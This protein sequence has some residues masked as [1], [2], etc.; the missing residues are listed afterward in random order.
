MR[1]T[2]L[3]SM[4]ALALALPLHAQERPER[5]QR[6]ERRVE[7]RVFTLRRA[8]EMGRR[9][10][11]VLGITTSTGQGLADTAGVLVQDVAENG[12]AARAGIQKGARLTEIDGIS[13][14][15]TPGDAEDPL[16]AS[17][18][19]RRLTRELGRKKPGDEVEL[20]VVTGAQSRNVRVRLAEP[21]SV[22]PR[23]APAPP[24]PVREAMRERMAN[25]ASLG[26][27]AGSSGSRRDTLGVFV[28]RADDDGPAARAGIVEGARIAAINGVDLRVDRA[29]ADDPMIAGAKVRQLM[30]E[31]RDVKPGDE[32]ELRVWQNGQYRTA[33][34][35]T[36]AADSLQ[37]TR[38]AVIVGDGPGV[39]G[40]GMRIPQGADFGA[41]QFHLA[42]EFHE[43]LEVIIDGALQGA[44]GAMEGAR[45]EIERV[46]RVQ[47]HH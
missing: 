22:F 13:L 15:M 30:R 16:L 37:R 20:R 33:R 27:Q 7:P 18:G 12:P 44:R 39:W 35:R 14:R 23:R 1:N 36:V 8:V 28:M 32:V 43:E 21:D 41:F 10:R 17:I 25:R 6:E 19:S 2:M 46:E 11:A 34:V 5:E 38:R 42:P 4:T 47:R 45:R 29:D 40:P 26:I 9:P 24:A 3:L 31:L